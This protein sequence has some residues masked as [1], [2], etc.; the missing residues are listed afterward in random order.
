MQAASLNEFMT[1]RFVRGLLSTRA[2]RAHLLNQVADAEATDEGAIFERLLTYVDDPKLRQ[3]ISRHQADE[4][5]HAELFRGCLER[6]GYSPKPVPSELKLLDRIDAL[7]DRV[8]KQPVK[9]DRDVMVS[10][11]LLLVIEERALSQFAQFIPAFD[12]VDPQ[13]ANVFREVAR[14]EARHLRYCHAISRRYAPGETTWRTNLDHFRSVEAKAFAFN[15]KANMAYVFEHDLHPASRLEQMGWKAMQSLALRAGN[16]PR[17]RYW[18]THE[19]PSFDRT[20]SD[21][22]ESRSPQTAE[23]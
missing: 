7:S 23:A 14:D 3:M 12:A 4:L 16:G 20:M 5:R 22:N 2:G 6:Q 10:Y 1:S 19:A 17:T 18:G 9:T 11:I 8:M 21:A 15:S 13:T